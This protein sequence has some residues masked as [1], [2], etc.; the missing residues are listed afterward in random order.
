MTS[1][2]GGTGSQSASVVQSRRRDEPL[3]RQHIVSNLSSAHEG[4]R[5]Q[6]ADNAES[7]QLV[8]W[9]GRRSSGQ[10]CRPSGAHRSTTCPIDPFS[11]GTRL[12]TSWRPICRELTT[13]FPRLQRGAVGIPIWSTNPRS[14]IDTNSTLHSRQKTKGNRNRRALNPK[15]RE[16]D[17]HIVSPFSINEHLRSRSSC[18]SETRLKGSRFDYL[19][20]REQSRTNALAI[21]HQSNARSGN[22]S[23]ISREELATNIAWLRISAERLSARITDDGLR[24]DERTAG[25]CT[26][27]VSKWPR[28]AHGS[29]NRRDLSNPPYTHHLFRQNHGMGSRSTTSLDC[30]SE[31]P[32]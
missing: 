25:Q 9:I 4:L 5:L 2:Q 29:S 28:A 18:S 7:H 19:I 30:P 24:S 21:S 22:G 3:A 8:E 31:R 32:P 6:Y 26:A 17:R 23:P 27:T 16:S 1:D 10:S 20:K 13:N 12:I 14:G 11:S 15:H